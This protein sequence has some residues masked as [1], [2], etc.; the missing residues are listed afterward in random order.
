[1]SNLLGED[2]KTTEKPLCVICDLE[3]YINHEGLDF[4]SQHYDGVVKPSPAH[5][6][7]YVKDIKLFRSFFGTEK[8]YS[9]L[10]I[11]NII[12]IKKTIALQSLARQL[13][14]AQDQDGALYVNK[15][16]R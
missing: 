3:S 7:I 13:N 6:Q 8:K 9:K 12:E 16:W 4:C 15:N 11:E 5:T 2:L 1:M 10:S 14:F